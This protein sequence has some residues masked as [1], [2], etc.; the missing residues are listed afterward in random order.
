MNFTVLEEKGRYIV[1]LR[2]GR[3]LFGQVRVVRVEGIAGSR[4]TVLWETHSRIEDQSQRGRGLGVALYS[5]AIEHGLSRGYRVT[6]SMG[7]SADALR[8]WRSQRL[9]ALYK[10]SYLGRRYWVAGRRDENS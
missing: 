2:A 7:P 6:S 10:I 4:R 8:C 5:A 1:E 9:N 3:E